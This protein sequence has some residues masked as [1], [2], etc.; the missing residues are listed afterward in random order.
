MVTIFHLTGDARDD[1]MHHVTATSPT[2]V[3]VHIAHRATQVAPTVL[4]VPALHVCPSFFPRS[5]RAL[6][7]ARLLNTFS[8]ASFVVERPIGRFPDGGV[9]G[10]RCH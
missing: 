3:S 6:R 5:P 7:A 9:I 2:P 4:T 1:A 10:E 8:R